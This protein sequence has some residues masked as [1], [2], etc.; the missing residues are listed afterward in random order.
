MAHFARSL[1]R[2]VLVLA[3]SGALVA[4][5]LVGV[6]YSTGR[7]VHEAATATEIP[8]PNIVT[9]AQVPSV[10]YAAN[11]SVMATLRSALNRQPV[12]LDQMAPVLVQ[13]VLDTEDHSFW[14]H[15][16]LDVESTVRAL[17]A[18]VNAGSVVQGGSTIAQQL[19]KGA[20]LTDQKTVSRKIR[21]AVLA[22]RLEERYSKAQILDAYLN[23]VY[24]GNGAYGVQAAAKEYFDQDADRVGVAQAALLAG[25][26]QAPSGYDPITNPVGARERR[27]E[28]L[29]RMVYY[30]SIT[31]AQATVANETPLPT[32]VHEAPGVS[33]TT[34]GY[35]VDE[36]VN[37]L[38][39]N[40]ALGATQD[41]RVS[42]LFSGG[43]KIYTN[44]VP[45]LQSDAQKVSVA[46]IPTSLP[47]VVAAFAVMDPRTG[48]VEALV[49]GPHP[50]T[51]QFD[52]AVQGQR[53]PGSGFKL[54]T[55]IAAL[56]SGYNVY[57]S[58]LATSPCAVVFPGVPL[59]NGYNLTNLMNNDPGDPGGVVSIVEATALSINCAFLRVA[60][61][62]TLQKVIDVARSMGVSDS[63][64]NP[65]NPSLVLGSEA[66]RPIEMAAAYATVAD[67]GIYHT[68]RFINRVVD[69]TGT[70]I[71]NGEGPGRRV[72]SAQVA[73]EALLAL[74]AT[75]QYGTGVAAALSNAD[76][77]GKTGTTEN[78]VDAW[79]NGVTPTLAASVWLGDP[80]GEVPMYVN[81]VE[82]F[83][84]DYPT[85]I[86][87]D[88][89]QFALNG[90]PYSAFPAP[91]PSLM[92]PIKYIFS[93]A[94]ERDD[95]L[96]HGGVGPT[97]CVWDGS[98]VPCPTTTTTT[99]TLPPG[100]KRVPTQ[101]GGVPLVLGHQAAVATP[102][103][104]SKTPTASPGVTKGP[105]Q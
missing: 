26:I 91:D 21:E 1:V 38:L 82:V 75:V 72:F 10:I 3:T 7:L 2:L 103:P 11:G 86:W 78:S 20:Y 4:A 88:V 12:A 67:G 16:G 30:K 47:N 14:V 39:D 40:P 105:S 61:E 60:H 84:A 17:L 32:M 80:K 44:E 46:D 23:F 41:E 42:A 81:G 100:P 55:L 28:V 9:D 51:D 90:V 27:S 6:A 54:F 104:T 43:L 92:P 34:D 52:D 31:P 48:N 71:Y 97:S 102:G 85:Q 101:A 25:L 62:V 66:V 35:Y 73:D 29:S 19:V 15:G 70:V 36:V 24:L 89:M 64:L 68:P 8:L 93:P 13:A 94:L 76:V 53:Q 65:L 37:E 45:S 98:I 58:V 99:T 63:T 59:A 56:E 69:R 95:L 83:G 18:D 74:R 77:A 50:G 79:F 5:G 96:S 33:Y 49:G 22:E 57:D 87:H